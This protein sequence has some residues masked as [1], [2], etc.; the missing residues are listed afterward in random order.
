MR[1]DDRD[2]APVDRGLAI[3]I[4]RCDVDLDWQARETLDPVLAD[5]S[6]DIGRAAAHDRNARE[7]CRID[8]PGEGLEPHRRHVEIVGERMADDFRL[9]VDLLGHEM[10]VVALFGEQ[11]SGRAHLDA[12]RDR[13]AGGVANVRPFPPE[14]HPVA[15][16]E[17]GD[18]VGERR[19]GKRVGAEIHLGLAVADRE[20]RPLP[21][22]DQQI[23]LAL[24]QVD[25]REGAAKAPQGRVDRLLG[26]LAAREFVLDDEGGDL[27]IR[28]GRERVA[29]GRELV[30][31]RLEVLDDAVVDD[32][33]PARGVRMGVGLGRLAVCRPTRMADADRTVERLSGELGLEVLEL[34]LGAPPRELSVLEGRD[35]GRVVAPI[36]DPLQ[37]LD[38]RARDRPRP[39]DAYNAAHRLLTPYEKSYEASVRPMTRGLTSHIG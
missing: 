30:A 20:R 18:T 26:R 16:L 17:I 12:P 36:F 28:F 39:Q 8:R 37:R 4:F 23:L 35:S 13:L 5:E 1:D 21:R 22:P 32:R 7:S 19:E 15:F 3:A 27:G 25:E 29:L 14:R 38:N 9:L 31:Q 11:A 10:P 33:K 34:A 6:G 24:E 2:A